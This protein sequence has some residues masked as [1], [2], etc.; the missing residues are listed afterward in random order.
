MLVILI[1][2][3]GGGLKRLVRHSSRPVFMRSG[4]RTAFADARSDIGH[5]LTAYAGDVTRDFRSRLHEEVAQ[6][7]GDLD[8]VRAEGDPNAFF[9]V[10]VIVDG[11][12][13]P[14]GAIVVPDVVVGIRIFILHAPIS[15][16]GV[17]HPLS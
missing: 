11:V 3:K 1:H 17:G 5:S 6:G 9:G 12:V 14:V 7:A 10:I 4:D 2:Q 13:A 8:V 16:R 15:T